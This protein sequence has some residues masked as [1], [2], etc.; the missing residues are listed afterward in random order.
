MSAEAITVQVHEESATA[1]HLVLPPDSRLTE[2]E[3]AE[4]FG[5]DW[6]APMRNPEWRF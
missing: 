6:T 2:D 3:M 1:F 4:V 5:G